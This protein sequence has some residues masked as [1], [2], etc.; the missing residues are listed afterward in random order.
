MKLVIILL[1]LTLCLS[2]CFSG[3]YVPPPECG[4]APS[5]ILEYTKGDP[6]ALRTGLLSVNVVG[7]ESK[8]YTGEQARLFLQGVD[9]MLMKN[10]SYQG[11]LTY[12]NEHLAKINKKGQVAMI[13]LGVDTTTI[14]QQGGTQIIGACDKALVRKHL[15]DQIL[16]S[17]FY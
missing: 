14:L 7:L 4:D 16:V 10:L 8:V 13:T 12:L 3:Q 11:L 15:N 1:T 9:N 2:G 6:R 5:I 17:S